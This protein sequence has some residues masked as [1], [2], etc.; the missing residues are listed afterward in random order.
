MNKINKINPEKYSVYANI[1]EIFIKSLDIIENCKKV[2]KI[3]IYITAIDSIDFSNAILKDVE[4]KII[5]K[6]Y[7]NDLSEINIENVSDD[8]KK[9]LTLASLS[10]K[11]QNNLIYEIYKNKLLI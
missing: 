1:N 8:T 4:K 7:E 5:K 11:K 10:S 3:K 9:T 6:K 2:V